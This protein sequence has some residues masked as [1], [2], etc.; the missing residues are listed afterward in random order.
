MV[1][2]A[3]WRRFFMLSERY[4]NKIKPQAAWG[5]YWRTTTMG[6]KESNKTRS[7]V[8]AI[9]AFAFFLAAAYGRA[10][11]NTN[12]LSDFSGVMLFV[13][14]TLA[15]WIALAATIFFMLRDKEGLKDIGFTKKN[16]PMQILFGVLAAIGSL[17][18]FLIVPEFFGVRMGYSGS[19]NI[20]SI[21]MNL[22]FA[23]LGVALVEEVV[24]RGHIFKKLMDF[25]NSKWF[26]IIVSSALF[27][28]FHIV[29]GISIQI[30]MATL[31]G[32]F[33]CICRDKIKHCT[34]LSLVI[35]HALHNTFIPVVTTLFFR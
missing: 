11:L 26:A 25:N 19:T 6:V 5:K 13:M 24:F 27:G 22:L 30:L 4:L 14:A 7:I 1:S 20:V 31:I 3:A 2:D 17:F 29:N 34:L 8:T 23:L 21:L 10:W 15:W 12:I 9:I 32:L 28:L 18:I 16:V 35:A 33:W